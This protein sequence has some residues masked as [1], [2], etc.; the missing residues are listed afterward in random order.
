[1]F[2][3]CTVLLPDSLFAMMATNTHTS[4]SAVRALTDRHT[5]RQTHR[6]TEGTDSITPTTDVGD[7]TNGLRLALSQR[8]IMLVYE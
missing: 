2:P 7:E 6:H 8:L 5:H 4:S 1:M 3:S